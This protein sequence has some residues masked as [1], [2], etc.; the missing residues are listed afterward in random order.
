M[1]RPAP[2]D[3]AARALQLATTLGPEDAAV[4]RALITRG[5]AVLAYDNSPDYIALEKGDR[6]E[7]QRGTS[8]ATVL[9]WTP[10]ARP[11]DSF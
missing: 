4:L 9:T 3:A 11:T 8:P 6:L 10:I 1:P 2:S 7:I 5:P